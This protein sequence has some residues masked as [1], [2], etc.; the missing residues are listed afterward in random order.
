M[1]LDGLGPVSVPPGQGLEKR[2]LRLGLR[3]LGGASVLRSGEMWP[4]RRPGAPMGGAGAR[5]HP[6]GRS[7]PWSPLVS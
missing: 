4:S 5:A 1:E 7:G 6:P 2:L 3:S